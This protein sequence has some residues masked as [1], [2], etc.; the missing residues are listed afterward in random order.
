MDR[1][2]EGVTGYL[3]APSNAAELTKAL[4]AVLNDPDS[5]AM[6]RVGR[7]RATQTYRWSRVTET[8]AAVIGKSVR[9]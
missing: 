6:G 4:L 1:V 2:E 3:V 9:R 7:Q 8:I 5:A